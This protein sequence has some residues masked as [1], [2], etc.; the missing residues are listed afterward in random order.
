MRD[1]AVDRAIGGDQRLADHL[2]AEH[3]LPA[4]LR[5]HAAKQIHLE[6]LDVEN[7]EE[8]VEGAAHDVGLY[9]FCKR[10]GTALGRRK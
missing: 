3:A 4:D 10:S 1:A 9:Q 6:R 7:G 2:P 8:L 5:A